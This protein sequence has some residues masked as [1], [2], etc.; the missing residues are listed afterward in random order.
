MPCRP[1]DYRN[2]RTKKHLRCAQPPSASAHRMIDSSDPFAVSRWSCRAPFAPESLLAT[3]HFRSLVCGLLMKRPQ[4]S[5]W[6]AVQRCAVRPVTRRRVRGWTAL[7][8]SVRNCRIL[9]IARWLLSFLH[10]FDCTVYETHFKLHEAMRPN[11]S[12]WCIAA[13]QF[14]DFCLLRWLRRNNETMNPHLHSYLHF[15]V[16][17]IFF[18]RSHFILVC[19]N[20]RWAATHPKRRRSVNSFTTVA[21]CDARRF[22]T[23]VHSKCTLSKVKNNTNSTGVIYTDRISHASCERSGRSLKKGR[24]A[25]N[26][27][28]ITFVF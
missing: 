3:N 18:S 19:L 9:W 13:S 17:C 4:L 7:T 8:S 5:D 2:R 16:L 27:L 24:A 1:R 20:Q 15:I 21:L 22:S 23:R 25:D 12:R 11:C 28:S 10:V 26:S 6:R 14:S